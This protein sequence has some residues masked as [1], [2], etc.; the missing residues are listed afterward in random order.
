MR[1]T[2]KE[3][4]SIKDSFDTVFKKGSLYLFGSRLDDSARGGDIDLFIKNHNI[5]NPTKLIKQI[6][7]FKLKLYEQIGEQKIDIVASNLCNQNIKHEATKKGVLI[8]EK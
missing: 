5:D 3:I 2:P 8:Y 6:R 7:S 4:D 1:L